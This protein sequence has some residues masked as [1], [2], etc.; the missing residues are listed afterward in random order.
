[1]ILWLRFLA[2]DNSYLAGA[3]RHYRVGRLSDGTSGKQVGLPC[4]NERRKKRCRK[5]LG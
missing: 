2:E 5:M 4:A 3:L 1:M